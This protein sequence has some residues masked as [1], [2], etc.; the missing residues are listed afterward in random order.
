MNKN[1][2]TMAAAIFGFAFLLG[3]CVIVLG[4]TSPSGKVSW[5]TR[6][7]FTDQTENKAKRDAAAEKFGGLKE[8]NKTHYWNGSV[9]VEGPAP[10]YRRGK[11]AEKLGGEQEAMKTHDW[12]GVSW[13]EKGYSK[14]SN[15][16]SRLLQGG[17]IEEPS[18]VYRRAQAAEKLGGVGEAMKT[19]DWNGGSWVPKDK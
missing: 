4:I 7:L 1:L 19:H 14:G 2:V 18:P 15:I 6:G 5:Y 10:S 16:P 11:A 13:V 9:F 12:N 17:L 3:G 8:A